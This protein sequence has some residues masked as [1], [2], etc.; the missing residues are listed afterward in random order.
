MGN[1]K[2]MCLTLRL[3]IKDKEK[4]ALFI[5]NTIYLSKKGPEVLTL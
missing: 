2:G 1:D 5:G 3:G 4:G